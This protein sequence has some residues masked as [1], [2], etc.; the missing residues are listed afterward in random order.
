MN[1]QRESI[2]ALRR[3]LLDGQIHITEEEIVDTRGYLLTLGRGA[4]R[5]RRSRPTRRADVDPEEWDLD[6]LDTA[7]SEIFGFDDDERDELDFG[8]KTVGR[9]DR[10]D[11]GAGAAASTRRRKR[12]LARSRRSCTASSATSCSR[13]STRSGR[14]TSTSLDHLKEGIGL[15]G[16]GQRDPLV[17]YKKESFA[18]F[19]AMR[20]R[21]EEEIVRYLWRLTPVMGDGPDG[22]GRPARRVRRRASRRRADDA[23]LAVGAAGLAVRRHRRRRA[24]PARA[25]APSAPRPARTGGDD[26]VRQVKRDEPK[27]GR[28]DPCPCGS[29]KKYKKCHGAKR[30]A[31]AQNGKQAPEVRRGDMETRTDILNA[32]QISVGLATALTFDDVLLVPQHSTVLPE[33]SRRL[34]AVHPQHPPERAARQRGD[35]HRDR[36]PAGHRDGAAGRHRRHPQEPD[37][38]G[39]GRRKSI[40]SS[41]RRAG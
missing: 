19:T 23:Q 17:E 18:L 1:K 15:R 33:R 10:R 29:G 8:G 6:A 9:D 22:A 11:L 34:V 38:R 28:N 7:V 21:V 36:I 16:Y 24:A 13:S 27:V 4:R 30:S 37:R 31:Q 3:E 41:G 12:L 20:D 35:G 40:A 5:E 25:A 14:T 26:V 32:D 2:Y 39:A